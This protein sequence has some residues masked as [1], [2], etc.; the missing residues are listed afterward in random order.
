MQLVG[1]NPDPQ[2]TGRDRLP[3]IVNYFIGKDPSKWHTDI[4]TY[5]KVAYHAVYPGIDLD[6]HGSQQQLEYDFVVSPGADPRAI[7]LNFAG[8]DQLEVDA[9]GD[10]LVHAGGTELRQHKPVL[11]Q[12]VNGVRHEV[13]GAFRLDSALV[14]HDSSLVTFAVGSYDAS[15]PLVIDPVLGYSTYLG[16]SDFD[17]ANAIA[18]DSSGSAYVAG[19]TLSANFPTQNPFHGHLNG[20]GDGFVAKLNA[21]GTA[22][23]YSTYLGGTSFLDRIMSIA[24][25]SAGSA[26]V[27]GF[28]NSDDFP[29][30]S[31]F[32]MAF[33]G[34]QDVFVTKL[35]PTG[36]QLAYSSYLGGKDADQ[37]LGIA[38][39]TAGNAYVTGRTNS[40]DFPTVNPFQSVLHGN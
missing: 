26:Y 32:Q 23:V 35:S 28:T 27:M 39:D 36:D 2:V 8:A 30:G 11:Y 9:S 29:V 22:L 17:N 4:P 10:L 31:G 15:R 1:A 5:A 6:Y 34:V 14:T 38:V 16:G 33:A 37:G 18:V 7:T 24:V 12:E 25:D 19:E 21:A 40:P 3:G 13:A 20:S